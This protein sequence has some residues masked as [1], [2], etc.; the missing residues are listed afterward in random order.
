MTS[1]G[2]EAP[3]RTLRDLGGPRQLPILGNLTLGIREQ[4]HLVWERW[5]NEHGPFFKA[6]FVNRPVL[7]VVDPAAIRHALQSRPGAFRRNS[8]IE[9]LMIEDGLLGVFGAEGE[10][11][12]RH[13]RLMNPSFQPRHVESFIPSI[14]EL[15]GRLREVL[16]ASE[17][18]VD[19]LSTA[20]KFTVDV[21]SRLSFGK[22][23]DT[24]RR[25]NHRI[26]QL[27]EVVMTTFLARVLF[28][29]RYWRYVRLPRDR[30]YD[31]ALAELRAFL[32]PIIDE[33]RSTRGKTDA[34]RSPT[35]LDTM[36][37]AHDDESS[38]TPFSDVEIYANVMTLLL[39]GEDT[40][41][42]TIAWML[43]YLARNPEVLSRARA[44]V[45]AVLGASLV[46]DAGHV[47]RLHYLEALFHETLRFRM[48]APVLFVEAVEDTEIA[49][50]ELPA[51]TLT[52]LYVRAAAQDPSLFGSPSSFRP[53]RWLDDPPAELLPHTPRQVFAFGGGPRVCPGRGLAVLEAVIAVATVLRSF[54]LVD[55][56][57]AKEIEELSS[58][59]VMPKGI[60][61][62][63]RPRATS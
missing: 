6:R 17:G 32:Q 54:D 23:L 63:F 53:D 34:S 24:Q 14:A 16:L 18:D 9:K 2:I 48:P 8:A 22:D 26:Q 30:A 43:H 37:H 13:R 39:A 27:A 52:L 40:T 31:H 35:V 50:I 60:S 38:K 58:F 62:R 3:K 5:A 57:P 49:G 55:P 42:T 46:P 44:E 41:A 7:G 19:V 25:G 51:G 20:M 56:D 36:I 10:T 21:T 45:D 47:P 29:F 33:A 4:P 61:L 11:W 28:P 1:A 12:R 59:T 15:A